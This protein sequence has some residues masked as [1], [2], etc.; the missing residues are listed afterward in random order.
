MPEIKSIHI[1][2]RMYENY[3][4]ARG[5]LRVQ[6]KGRILIVVMVLK[7]KFFNLNI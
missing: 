3:R 5:D 6:N 7:V 4:G 2:S 1:I